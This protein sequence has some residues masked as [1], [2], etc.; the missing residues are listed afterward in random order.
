[1]LD[2]YGDMGASPGGTDGLFYRDTRFLSR[3]Q[4]LVNEAQPLLLGSNLRDDNA[5]LVV[6]LTIPT[7][8]PISVSVLEKD[9]VHI[10]RTIFLWQD[11]VYQ[12]LAVRNY[13]ARDDRCA[14]I[15]PVRERFRRSVRGTRG[16]I[17]SRRGNCDGA[18]ARQRSSAAQL[19]RPRRQHCGAQR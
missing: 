5:A 11:T 9:T 14:P 7:S 12:R 17:A 10:L 19:S 2:T 6:D 8:L 13:G 1:V 4:L 3:L 18:V 16:P 15:D